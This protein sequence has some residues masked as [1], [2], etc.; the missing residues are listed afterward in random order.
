MICGLI[1]NKTNLLLYTKREA[2]AMKDFT[3]PNDEEPG[4]I[5][6]P[7]ALKPK[8]PKDS[9]KGRKHEPNIDGPQQESQETDEIYSDP[10]KEEDLPAGGKNVADLNAYDLSQKGNESR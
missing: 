3:Q 9:Y 7:A 2:H 5:D 10:R 1:N 4:L 8:N 6:D